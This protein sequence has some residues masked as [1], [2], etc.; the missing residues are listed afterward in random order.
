MMGFYWVYEQTKYYFGSQ[1][2]QTILIAIFRYKH[3]AE[4][5]IKQKKE[6]EKRM[7]WDKMEMNYFIEEKDTF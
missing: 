3:D 2:E 7:E 6:I 5:F 1:G 4:D